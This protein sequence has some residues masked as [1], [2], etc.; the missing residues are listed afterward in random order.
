M[1]AALSKAESGHSLE[2]KSKLKEQGMKKLSQVER[3]IQLFESEMTLTTKKLIREIKCAAPNNVL[4]LA[5]ERMDKMGIKVSTYK[6]RVSS[7]SVV[8]FYKMEGI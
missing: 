1:L 2:A 8:K 4:K 7:G 5:I 6:R 3:T